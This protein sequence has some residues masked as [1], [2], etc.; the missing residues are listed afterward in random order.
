LS[1]PQHKSFTGLA[2]IDCACHWTS[3]LLCEV[4]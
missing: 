1:T 4:S 2:F 3:N